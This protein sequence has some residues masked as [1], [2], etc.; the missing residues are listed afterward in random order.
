[1][2]EK[3]KTWDDI[4]H[5][6]YCTHKQANACIVDREEAYSYIDTHK[7]KVMYKAELKDGTPRRLWS[8]ID[9]SGGFAGYLYTAI[10]DLG[11]KNV[12]KYKKDI[13]DFMEIRIGRHEY[14]KDSPDNYPRTAHFIEK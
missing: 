7:L 13:F 14:Q 12:D 8:L 3:E 9:G 5:L 2:A 1:M 6:F 10:G 4:K 11:Y